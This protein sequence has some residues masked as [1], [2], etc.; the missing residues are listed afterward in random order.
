MHKIGSAEV[1]RL[2]P[3]NQANNIAHDI[4]LQLLLQLSSRSCGVLQVPTKQQVKGVTEDLRRRSTVPPHVKT[5]LE[6]MPL[7]THPM[8]QLVTLV[9]AMQVRQVA[10]SSETCV[11]YQL[12]LNQELIMLVKGNLAEVLQL[13]WSV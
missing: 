8:T 10:M 13:L 2:S 9:A 1:P 4:Y 3:V 5:M 11:F 7:D 12:R 6:A